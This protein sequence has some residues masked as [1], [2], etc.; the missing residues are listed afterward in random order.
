MTRMGAKRYTLPGLQT[1]VL[2]VSFVA[3]FAVLGRVFFEAAAA[4]RPVA[5]PKGE[6]QQS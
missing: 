3:A 5:E 1:F 4:A 6:A 2:F